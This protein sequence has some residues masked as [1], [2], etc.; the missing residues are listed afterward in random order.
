M[1]CHQQRVE[2][3]RAFGE[4]DTHNV[5]TDTDFSIILRLER[6]TAPEKGLYK[7]KMLTSNHVHSNC[8]VRAE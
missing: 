5:F 4:N 7:N 2:V 1:S 3:V 8:A 6:L